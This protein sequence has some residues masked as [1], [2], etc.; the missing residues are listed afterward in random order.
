M[1]GG[2]LDELLELIEKE[3]VSEADDDE[4]LIEYELILKLMLLQLL[5]WQ[6][7]LTL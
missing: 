6:L 7:S 1:L 4:E 2:L 5:L 3:E